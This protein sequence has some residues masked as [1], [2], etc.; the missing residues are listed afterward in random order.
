MS[1]GPLHGLQQ[2]SFEIGGL[3]DGEQHGMIAALP[4]PFQDPERDPGIGGSV[5]T[6]LGGVGRRG[7]IGHA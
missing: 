1:S 7:R 5:A 2:K 6:H 4:E 3:G